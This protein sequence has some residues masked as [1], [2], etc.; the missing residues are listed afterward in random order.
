MILVQDLDCPGLK[1]SKTLL[2]LCK[3]RAR[4]PSSWVVVVVV[5]LVVVTIP[6]I[7]AVVAVV[8]VG[9]RTDSVRSAVGADKA[10]TLVVFFHGVVVSRLVSEVGWGSRGKEI[11]HK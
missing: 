2:D 6:S 1:E 5:L 3:K 8:V 9:R 7:I 11:E 10:R 4:V